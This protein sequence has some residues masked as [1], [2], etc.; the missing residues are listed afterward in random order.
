MIEFIQLSF[1]YKDLE[2]GSLRKLH[3][4]IPKGQC[5]LLCGASGCGKTTL[6][7]LVNGLIPHFFEGKISGKVT[8]KGMNVAETE[9][10]TLS[11]S[12]GTVFQNPR[13][14]FFNTDT[15]S[16]IVFGL[17]NR[18]LEPEELKQQLERVVTDLH[19]EK[20]RG[21][22]IFDLSGG[23]KQKIAFAS[24]Y[25]ANPDIF[26][27][28]EPSSNL[29]FHSVLE[30]KNLIEKIKRQG[31]TIIIAEHRL[32]YLI[33]IADRVIL[34]EDGQ[35][36]KDMSMQ[37]FCSLPIKQ[38]QNMG[39]RCRNFSEIETNINGK[40]FSEHTL[41]LKDIHV[42][43]GNHIVLRNISFTANGG[44]I[45]AITGANGAGKTTLARTICGLL[46]Q[47]SGNIFI[48]GKNLTAKARI[49]KSYMVMQ[50]VGHQLFTDSVKTECTLG[51]KTKNES[52]IDE[53]LSM[54]SLSE[55]KNRHPLALSG[56]QKQRLAVAISLLCDKEILIFDEPTSGLDLKSMRE[57]GT[58]IERLSEQGKIL[59]VITHDIEFIKTICSRVL[60]LSGG[61]MIA[62]LKDKEKE[63]IENYI[64][65]GGYRNE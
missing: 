48:N 33:D 29:D 26:V 6:T 38:I 24:V 42:K 51:T 40:K 30:L 8:I 2:K 43:Y 49:K 41:E 13:T 4:K 19:I 60:L 25:A 16:E 17:E 45:V 15:D 22:S 47:K 57:V 63:N 58:M 56:G 50:D 62:D 21:C 53:I 9:I 28:D 59:L 32:W 5:V 7:R 46:K 35:I 20:L 39:L 61:K 65:T 55:L 31:K 37:D 64:L 36:L 34:M 1:S 54:L 14:Q 52:Y 27:L 10:S 3:L 11:D 23:E 44:E 12:V 18:M